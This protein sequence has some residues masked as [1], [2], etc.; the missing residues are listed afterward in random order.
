MIGV[1]EVDAGLVV[2]DVA[3]GPVAIGDGVLAH[4]GEPA[5]LVRQKLPVDVVD[6]KILG[7]LVPSVQIRRLTPKD[8]VAERARPCGLSV[9]R[10]SDE[11]EGFGSFG[12]VEFLTKPFLDGPR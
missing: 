2:D 8:V 9:T 6:D 12:L 10:R 4:G 5:L 11:T 3:L 1:A 7:F